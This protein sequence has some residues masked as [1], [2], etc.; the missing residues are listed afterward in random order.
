MRDV[1]ALYSAACTPTGVTSWDFSCITKRH[2]PGIWVLDKY[3][4]LYYYYVT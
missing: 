2:I 4:F 1:T 3:Y